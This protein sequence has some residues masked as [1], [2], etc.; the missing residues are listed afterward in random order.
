VKISI[1]LVTLGIA[2]LVTVLALGGGSSP[3]AI[4]PVVFH[5]T[6]TVTGEIHASEGFTDKTTAKNV[7]SCAHAATHGDRPSSGPNT[8]AV[9]TPE[10]VND[11]V[12]IQIGTSAGAYHGPGHYSQTVL[13]KGNGAMGVGP[14]T[15]DLTSGDAT[16]SMTV[17]ADGSGVVAFT[18]VPGDDDKPYA[19]WHGGIT[20]TIAWT[21]TS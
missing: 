21:C 19:G 8:W 5:A 17:N 2:V 10:S 9:P 20:G 1:G 13:A 12:E 4:G 11:P 7:P 6:I 14:E 15:Y 18:H 3:S 16:A